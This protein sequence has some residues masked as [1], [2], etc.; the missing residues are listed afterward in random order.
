MVKINV[1]ATIISMHA[2]RRLLSEHRS[3][4]RCM[5][6]GRTGPEMDQLP[7]CTLLRLTEVDSY[8]HVDYG[9]RARRD[10]E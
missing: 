5:S 8:K 3:P 6:V 1:V 4:N 9:L 10:C 7:W 2:W